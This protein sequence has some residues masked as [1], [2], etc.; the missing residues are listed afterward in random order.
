[1]HVAIIIHITTFCLEEKRASCILYC[2]YK[3]SVI[4]STLQYQKYS[5]GELY[6]IIMMRCC[7]VRC[8][9]HFIIIQVCDDKVIG[10]PGSNMIGTRYSLL[11]IR[12]FE[13]VDV[14]QKRYL[15]DRVVRT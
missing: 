9:V 15:Q 3:N 13:I 1:M 5:T 10:N 6:M 12:Y 14:V 4:I 8:V 11:I 2:N 7:A